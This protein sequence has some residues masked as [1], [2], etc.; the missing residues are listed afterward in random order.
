MVV[1]CAA[2]IAFIAFVAF[3]ACVGFV[4][5]AA[6]VACVAC[7]A[8]QR[9]TVS[10][11]G[12][13]HL[14]HCFSFNVSSLGGVGKS[15][16]SSPAVPNY[17]LLHALNHQPD[18]CSAP[19]ISWLLFPTLLL[20]SHTSRETYHNFPCT[21]NAN[22]LLNCTKHFVEISFFLYETPYNTVLFQTFVIYIILF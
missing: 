22:V 11:I 3:V 18:I 13:R 1:T 2:F 15:I 19:R 4:G 12:P 7:V 20:Y 17:Y 14:C 8:C 21:Y 5:V 10:A 6:F 9:V 16:L